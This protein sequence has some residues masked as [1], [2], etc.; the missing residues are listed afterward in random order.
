M[1]NK[2]PEGVVIPVEADDFDDHRWNGPPY[3]F[4]LDPDAPEELRNMFSVTTVGES[5][6]V[7]HSA[8]AA[9][10]GKYVQ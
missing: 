9:G 5:I 8:G 1:E 6:M 3:T 10:I 4:V 7:P 2:P